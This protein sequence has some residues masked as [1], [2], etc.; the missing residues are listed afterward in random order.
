MRTEVYSAPF[1]S[2]AASASGSAV[3]VEKT[4]K[5]KSASYVHYKAEEFLLQMPF[6]EVQHALWTGLVNDR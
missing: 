2:E 4:L 3:L 5:V 1:S 6:V